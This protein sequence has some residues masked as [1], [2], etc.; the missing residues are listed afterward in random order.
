[1]NS[2]TTLLIDAVDRTPA[3]A[4]WRLGRRGRTADPSNRHSRNRFYR[5]GNEIRRGFLLWGL[6]DACPRT[7]DQRTCR[8]VRAGITQPLTRAAPRRYQLSGLKADVHRC[9]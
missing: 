9:K 5:N 4:T 1:M 2:H 7:A 6:C 8:R 3:I